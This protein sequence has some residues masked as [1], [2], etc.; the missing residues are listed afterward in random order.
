VQTVDELDLGVLGQSLWRRKRL[1][2]GLTL[3]AAALAF[4]AVNL[5]TPRYKSEARVLIETRE[6][7]FAADAKSRSTHPTVDPKR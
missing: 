2:G 4:L 1:I 7:I 3:L 6:N 5:V